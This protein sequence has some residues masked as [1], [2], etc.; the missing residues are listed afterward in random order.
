MSKILHKRSMLLVMALTL[1]LVSVA[2]SSIP[3][4]NAA[5]GTWSTPTIISD[6][7]Q[8]GIYPDIA[9]DSQNVSHVIYLST[10]NFNTQLVIRY[11]NNRGGSWSSPVAISNLSALADFYPAISTVTVNGSV[12]V[13]V[14]YVQRGGGSLWYRLSTDGGA[15]WAPL[16]QIRPNNSARPALTL[17][18]TG[19]PHVVYTRFDGSIGNLVYTTRVGGVWTSSQVLNT[20]ATDFNRDTSIV[21]TRTGSSL[22]IH[23]VWAGRPTGGTGTNGQ[24]WYVRKVDNGSWSSPQSRRTNGTSVNYPDLATDGRSKLFGTWQ[25]DISGDF[26]PFFARSLDAGLTWTTAVDEGT[27]TSDIGRNPSIAHTPS[28][29]LAIVWEDK[30]NSKDNN[31]DIYSRVSADE[32]TTWSN[33]L[34]VQRASGLSVEAA[35][36]GGT[37]GFQSV[38]HDGASGS[39]AIYTSGIAATGTVVASV[40]ATPQLPAKTKDTTI[41]VS[42]TNIQG[43]PKELRWR[44]GAA[45]TDVANDSGGWQPFTNPKPIPLPGGA[46]SCQSLTLFTQVR[47][48]SAIEPAAKSAAVVFDNTVQAKVTI[49]NPYLSTLPQTFASVADNSTTSASDGDPSYTRIPQFF[50]R[51]SD[52]G[53]CSGLAS[54]TVPASNFSGSITNGQYQNK[55]TLPQAAN[56]TPGSLQTIGVSVLDGLSNFGNYSTGIIYDPANT[57]TTGTQ[58]NTLGL[59]VVHAGSVTAN[60]A[61]NVIQTL[62]FSANLNVTDNVYGPRESLPA[63]RQFWGVWIANA[64]SDVGA[65]N[66]DLQWYPVKVASPGANQVTVKW[67]VFTGLNIGADRTKPGTYFVYVRFLDGA[68]NPSAP[69]TALKTTVA[70]PAGYTLPTNAAP[71]ISK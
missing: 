16:E 67:S 42:F 49:S 1:A 21:S 38:W 25:A 15:T 56:T 29:A 19:Q 70:L 30:Y 9:T 63:T 62:T 60:N 53:D 23:V 2:Q 14:V 24:V 8:Q 6:R 11:M 45:P 71:F 66:S 55:V 26:E 58:T 3:H 41:S 5:I 10:P 43:A 48:G 12:Y 36:S 59:P 37:T 32:G 40:A 65:G 4:A 27:F 69:Q 28:G 50:L 64:T 22:V 51:I 52:A 13:A 31:Y 54:F 68:G 18:D 61:A 7:S 47:D 17:D 33:L 57:D 20:S 46:T 34:T 44:W 39:L 35:V